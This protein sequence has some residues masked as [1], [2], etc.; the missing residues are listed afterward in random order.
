MQAPDPTTVRPLPI[1]RKTLDWLKGRWKETADY[2]YVCDQFKSLRQDLTVQRIRNDFTVQVYE[3]HARIALEKGDL[4][5]YNQCQTQLKLLYD[6]GHQ[7]NAEE[8]LAYRILYLLHTC[9]R[10]EMN[11]LMASLSA[12]QHQHPAI[13]HA[14]MVRSALALSNYVLFFKLYQ[15]C[16]NMGAFLMDYYVKRERLAALRVMCR[17]YRPTLSLAYLTDTLD[18]QDTATMRTFLL[19]NNFSLTED[20]SSI[21]CKAS[22][23]T[24]YSS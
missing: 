1:L 22:L 14:L 18:E 23:A 3:I 6:E 20:Q 17:A 15:S 13:K 7:G 5:E 8:F 11:S 2:N 16:P 9:N 4:G 10:Q 12:E 24:A 19:A 21:D